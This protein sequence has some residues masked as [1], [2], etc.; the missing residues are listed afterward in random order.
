GEIAKALSAAWKE[1]DETKL[2]E[3]AIKIGNSAVVK[4][5]GFLMEILALGDPQALRKATHLAS[6]FSPLDP[7]LPKKGR[8]SRRW[9]LLINAEVGR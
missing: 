2:R 9:G 3:Y 4:R 1:L 7:T 8:H 6:G 5:L